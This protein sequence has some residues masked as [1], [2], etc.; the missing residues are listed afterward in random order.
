MRKMWK[1]RNERVTIVVL[2]FSGD[3][4]VRLR[5]TLNWLYFPYIMMTTYQRQPI[6]F[7]EPISHHYNGAQLTAHSSIHSKITMSHRK[8][9]EKQNKTKR[10]N[11]LFHRIYS[12]SS[13]P[14]LRWI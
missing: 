14:Y 1:K 10:N 12:S 6:L 4:R 2:T 8:S 13:S 3:N 11:A 7:N 5:A 9:H